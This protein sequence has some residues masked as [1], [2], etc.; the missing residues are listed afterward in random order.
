MRD[1]LRQALEWFRN[2]GGDGVLM[3]GNALLCGGEVAPHRWS[4][5]KALIEGGHLEQY[6]AGGGR[7]VRVVQ[8]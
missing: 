5:W 6:S 7:R 8:K 3:R 2:R 4:T 1:A